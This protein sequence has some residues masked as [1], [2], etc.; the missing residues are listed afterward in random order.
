VLSDIADLRAR[1]ISTIWRC[2][3]PSKA[4]I[5]DPAKALSDECKDRG[6]KVE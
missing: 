3:S 2:Q 4:T 5:C 1:R 6:S